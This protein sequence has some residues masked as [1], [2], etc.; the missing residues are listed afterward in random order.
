[1]S[2]ESSRRG[3]GNR[4]RGISFERR[5]VRRFKE[6][7]FGARRLWAEQFAQKGVND[8]ELTLP[9]RPFTSGHPEIS[10][11]LPAAIQCK[12]TKRVGD[13]AKG[14]EEACGA[15]AELYACIHSVP[16]SRKLKIAVVHAHGAGEVTWDE[17]L[18][19]LRGLRFVGAIAGRVDASCPC[20]DS[21][22]AE[23]GQTAS[24]LT[25]DRATPF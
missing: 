21:A 17:L 11:I 12:Y 6:A 1:M 10:V 9:F 24:D 7:G 4:E 18:E 15:D 2:E 25:V 20:T 19:L 22:A 13:L 3:R 14:L 16:G 8:I 23:V 5:I